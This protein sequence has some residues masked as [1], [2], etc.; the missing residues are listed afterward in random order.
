[1][2]ARNGGRTGARWEWHGVEASQYAI[3]PDAPEPSGRRSGSRRGA[4]V[5]LYMTREQTMM[6]FGTSDPGGGCV[7][8]LRAPPL[9]EERQCT[10]KKNGP[11]T[12]REVGD[13]KSTYMPVR[14]PDRPPVDCSGGGAFRPEIR[15]W[16]K[17]KFRVCLDDS[18]SRCALLSTWSPV[19]VNGRAAPAHHTGSSCLSPADHRG[20][21]V[22]AGWGTL[23][24]CLGCSL[25]RRHRAHHRP[26]HPLA[27]NPHIS[28]DKTIVRYRGSAGRG[29][30]V[31]CVSWYRQP[32]AWACRI[33][34]SV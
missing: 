6:M 31:R 18:T 25:P 28:G 12:Q 10:R 4:S 27:T 1:V 34:G 2:R 13:D 8:C 33:G 16:I 30:A 22:R 23:T 17:L 11:I 7:A 32:R 9:T 21:I 3:L 14:L 26:H 20:S 19:Q 29:G 15:A 5:G 24:R